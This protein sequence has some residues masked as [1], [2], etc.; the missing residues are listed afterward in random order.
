M[1]GYIGI[2]QNVTNNLTNLISNG[3]LA[4]NTTGWTIASQ[5]DVT[6]NSDSVSIVENSTVNTSETG[7][8]P[9]YQV[10]TSVSGSTSST[11]KILYCQAKVCGKPSNTNGVPRIYFRRYKNGSSSASYAPNLASITTLS[12]PSCEFSSINMTSI[13]S[14]GYAYA[15]VN[16]GTTQ[17]TTGII[18]V[19]YGDIVHIYMERVSGN[20]G[21]YLYHDKSSPSEMPDYHEYSS[22][23]TYDWDTSTAPHNFEHATIV[24]ENDDSG[25]LNCTIKIDWAWETY[26]VY[27]STYE[28][29]SN[30]YS[31][32]RIAFGMMPTKAQGE[33][34]SIKDIVLVNLTSE[35]GS[36]NE[37]TKTWC[38]ENI[39]MSNGTPVEISGTSSLANKIKNM[40]IGINGV[41]RKVKKAYIGINNI[42]RLWYIDAI[43]LYA[44]IYSGTT[45][46]AL[47]ASKYGVASGSLGDY[48]I[49]AGGATNML[50]LLNST[51][52]F[53][54]HVNAYNSSLVRSVLPNITFQMADAGTATLGSQFM[55]MGGINSATGSGSSHAETTLDQGIFYTAGL[56]SSGDAFGASLSVPRASLTGCAIGNYAVFAGGSI[57]ISGQDTAS[58]SNVVDAYSSAT[59]A[60]TA[61]TALSYS[62]G[63]LASC[64]N[65]N[66]VIFAGGQRYGTAFYV[67]KASPS[68]E[69][70]NIVNAYNSSL[71]KQSNPTNLSATESRPSAARA[72]NNLLV[73]TRGSTNGTINI[74]N[75]SNLSKTTSATLST[76]R[77]DMDAITYNG[78]A[79]FFGGTLS[80]GSYS[81]SDIQSAVD[82][83]T[84]DGIHCILSNLSVL[85]YDSG[86]ACAG[87]KL[88]VAG[89]KTSGTLATGFTNVVDVYSLQEG[90]PYYAISSAGNTTTTTSYVSSYITINND[91]TNKYYDVQELELSDGDTIHIWGKCAYTTSSSGNTTYYY[92]QSIDVRLNGESVATR[93][94]SSSTRSSYADL[95][96]YTVDSSS[97]VTISLVYNNTY[98]TSSTIR[99]AYIDINVQPGLSKEA[100]SQPVEPTNV[101]IFTVHDIANN[102][103]FRFMAENNMTWSTFISSNYNANYPTT[104]TKF[105]TISSSKVRFTHS[106]GTYD[107]LYSN[108]SATTQVASTSTIA[109]T[110]YYTNDSSE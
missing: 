64:A 38:D 22:S 99:T 2:P 29:S 23:L 26:S 4:S 13:P 46:D 86:V 68:I 15:T 92:R 90:V 67:Y 18:N 61:P 24:F 43:K 52:N 55:I 73:A 51:L 109:A 1:A 101:F 102:I 65:D 79:V 93:T 48:A 89:G 76:N 84:P 105:F 3:S 21:V 5:Y 80:Q 103:D 91:T 12:T 60:V 81:S 107:Y 9:C 57:S 58:F 25:Y 95:Y 36:G 110:T 11:N 19:T 20:S 34:M 14:G 27:T 10:F 78:C 53:D 77:F 32:D 33:G 74:Y 88:L 47:S 8:E 82:M 69:G 71:V 96:D 50:N 106:G 56:V 108:S 16:S 59:V 97:V 85:R 40:Y 66:Y 31:Y 62:A 30:Y 45:S 28:D 72:G 37:P 75:G 94:A 35:Y 49:F 83:Y 39:Y 41:A 104:S 6:Q 98:S 54:K 100:T 7:V 87:D 17:Y 70:S 63:K 44:I 42:A